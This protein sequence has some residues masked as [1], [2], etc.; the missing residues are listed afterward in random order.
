MKKWTLWLIVG[1]MVLALVGLLLLQL[2][3][4]D[5]VYKFRNE[6]FDSRVRQSLSS[7]S[8]DAELQETAR[9]ISELLDLPTSSSVLSLD[10]SRQRTLY[11]L[12][13]DSLRFNLYQMPKDPYRPLETQEPD[14]IQMASRELMKAMAT[15][16][17]EVREMV[18]QLAMLSVKG[19]N[20]AP[21]YERI[22]EKDLDLLLAYYLNN[23]GVTLPYVYEVSDN[24]H[25]V[26]YSS[27]KIPDDDGA[28]TYSQVLYPKDN[29]SQMYF[30]RLYFPGKRQLLTGSMDFLV[31]SLVFTLLLVIV[32][33]VTI[34][35]LFR[36]KKL[37]ELRKDF[38]NNMTHEL[39]T[40]VSTIMVASQMLNSENLDAMPERRQKWLSSIIAEGQRLELLIDKVLQM[41]FFDRD[42]VKLKPKEIDMEELL[43]NVTNIFSLKVESFG[44]QIDVD[45]GAEEALVEGDE[46][47][48]TNIIF[49]LLDNAVKYRDKERE[50]MLVVGTSSD[51]KNIKIYIRDNGIGM[52]RE[53]AKKIF[54]R[55]YRVPTGNR[56][57]VK[58][59]GL[60]LSYVYHIV[61]LHHGQIAVESELGKGTKFI[62]TL[63][64][65]KKE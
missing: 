13:S 14:R 18:I 44:G 62:I 20:P 19:N 56:H 25:R 4:V 55:F 61:E 41:S 46:M 34:V 45:L 15:R 5:V 23:N 58:G 32:F 29:P 39:K 63:P 12:Q 52:K 21:I 59:Y 38:V 27:G 31:P 47:H 37:E 2:N 28:A 43:L 6:Q 65:L 49:N 26:Y 3:Y 24:N 1:A 16:Y 51:V 7:V 50:L 40:P 8:Q 33:T 36:Q 17:G 11:Q 35:S 30:V 9:L 64:L 42:K 10:R 53:H 57:D 48:L 22:S 54:G 60:G